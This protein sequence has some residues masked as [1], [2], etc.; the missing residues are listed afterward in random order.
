MAETAAQRKALASPSLWRNRDYLL[1]WAGQTVSMAGSNVSGIAFPLLVLG[2]THSP[3]QMGIVEALGALPYVVLSLPAGAYIDRWNRKTTMIVCDIGRAAA[4]ATVPLALWADRLSLLQLYSVAL[5]GGIL[6]VFFD[7]AAVA[8]LPR[9]VPPQQLPAAVAQGE[10]SAY[11]A[12]LLGPPL[13]GFLY[14]L[15]ASIPFVVDALSY[16][17]SVAGLIF[18]KARFQS[19][20]GPA[21][22]SIRAEITLGLRWLWQH[23]L[24]RFLALV[25]GGLNLVLSSSGVILIIAAKHLHASPWIIG[26]LFASAGIGGILGAAL[27][28]VVQKRLNFGPALIGVVWAQTLIWPL[29]A[30][31]PNV[32]VLGIANGALA[33]VGPTFNVVLVSYRLA[34]IPDQLQ[35]RVNSAVRVLTFGTP[36]LS[37]ALAGVLLQVVDLVTTVATFG[38]FLLILAVALTLNGNVRTARRL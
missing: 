36:P 19:D 33:F 16:G 25:T 13:G 15:Q 12:G 2:L 7:L 3:A 5:V 6:F 31:A 30:V 10:T 21:R 4:L 11:T 35:G 23:P 34:H 20:A 26:M 27:A 9:V 18:M 32:I 38:G 24:F 8:A 28:P 22:T 1:L 29:Y 14:S 37:L 17:A